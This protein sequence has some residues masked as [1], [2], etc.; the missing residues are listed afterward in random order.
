[1]GLARRWAA[2]RAADRGVIREAGGRGRRGTTGLRVMVG[3]GL[4]AVGVQRRDAAPAGRRREVLVAE[5]ARAGRT[6]VVVLRF[7]YALYANPDGDLHEAARA[8]KTLRRFRS[9]GV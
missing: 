2:R 8:T 9:F 6:L 1:M 3:A 5:A 7:H 4:R